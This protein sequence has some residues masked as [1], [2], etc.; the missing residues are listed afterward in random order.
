MAYLVKVPTFVF[1]QQTEEGNID[2]SPVFVAY[3]KNVIELS[4][5]EDSISIRPDFAKQLFEE[6]IKHQ[7]DAKEWHDERER[8]RERN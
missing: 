4:Q 5:G 2:E 3:F 8:L 6:I 7:E 1:N